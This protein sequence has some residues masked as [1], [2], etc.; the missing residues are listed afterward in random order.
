MRDM[1]L[2]IVALLSL[3]SVAVSAQPFVGDEILSDALRPSNAVLSGVAPAVS[4]AQDLQGVAMAWTARNAAG[5]NVLHVAR[6]D[7]AGRI[8][9]PAAAI[10]AAT[11][12][13]VEAYWPSIAV[14]PDRMGFTL[15]WVEFLRKPLTDS[16]SAVY[17]RL[18]ADLKPS[19]RRVLATMQAT[20]VTA[21]AIVR[22]GRATWISFDGAV[23]EIG[24]DGSLGANLDAGV[25]VSDMLATSDFPKVVGQANR[26]VNNCGY[27]PWLGYFPGCFT[28]LRDLRFV[29]L[30]TGLA[31]RR[32]G[33]RTDVW[34]VIQSDGRDVLVVWRN[35]EQS[36]GGPVTAVRLSATSF[37]A[38]D[39]DLQ[40]GFN[41]GTF[42]PDVVATRPGIATDGERYLVV[43]STKKLGSSSRDIVGAVIDRDNQVIP[44]S[45]AATG[46]DERDPSILMTAPGNFLVAYEKLS[47][48]ERRLATRTVKFNTRRRAAR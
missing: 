45:I 31:T 47:N 32:L 22:S 24:A 5:A 1:R 4:L 20:K 46:A 44:L 15:A 29:S 35:G 28:N 23:R 18:D 3:S 33:L 8:V 42:G 17:C 10:P 39:V 16:A 21:P 38:V 48:G 11:A 41:I 25:P 2:L 26:S 43:W 12:E 36:D 9:A 30:Q 37:T 40:G 34:P 7:L 6:L 14:A 19:A 13:D 27:I